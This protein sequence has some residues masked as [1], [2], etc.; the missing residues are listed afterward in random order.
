MK[1]RFLKL[2]LLVAGACLPGSSLPAAVHDFETEYGTVGFNGPSGVNPAG[3][4]SLR[5]QAAG[6][7][8]Q[9][10]DNYNLL[11]GH[12]VNLLG[13]GLDSW[14]RNSGGSQPWIGMNLTGGTVFGFINNSE[15]FMLPGTPSIAVIRWTA[16]EA[17][18]AVISYRFNDR[19]GGGDGSDWYVALNATDLAS[20]VIADLGD[21]GLNTL[22]S[23]NLA[24]GDHINWIVGAG[25][26]GDNAADVVR[27]LAR[28]DFTPKPSPTTN[29][30]QLWLKAD[31]ITALNSGA[32]VSTW[33][34]VSAN[35][36]HAI[37]PAGFEPSF[38]TNSLN[39][40]PS[41][42]FADSGD[43]AFYNY[44]DSPLPL[45]GNSQNLA[46]F[47]VFRSARV[48][49]RD[50]LVQTLN[51]PS[52]SNGRTML[53]TDNNLSGVSKVFS[54]AS[55][56]G[57]ESTNSYVSNSWRLVTLVQDNAASTLALTHEGVTSIS[58]PLVGAGPSQSWR[59]GRSKNPTVPHGLAGDIAEVLLYDRVLTGAERAVVEAYL[60]DKWFTAPR[61][62]I[63]PAPLP[64]VD[65]AWDDVSGNFGLESTKGLTPPISW[66]PITT[67][68]NIAGS[69][70]N[71]TVTAWTP[72]AT[73]DFEA[74]FAANPTNN[75]SGVWS[76]LR[77]ANDAD[78]RLRDDNYTPLVF[79]E[80]ALLG[81]SGLVAWERNS[82]GTTPWIG[83][84]LTGGN[85]FGLLDN[86]M[87][88][89]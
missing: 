58:T 17:G 12:D 20:G 54:F 55:G 33:N 56:T 71:Y 66:T 61:L 41:V 82:G 46:L 68:I 38:V 16:P 42:R 65:V 19:Q 11:T 23:V 21:T 45:S 75:P 10:D 26:G 6:A 4:W 39:G 77:Q 8:T 29:G 30:L 87:S 81:Q 80:P 85:V 24:A 27:T 73:Y 64:A 25:S 72:G 79:Y 15:S 31:A 83:I 70:R 5:Y 67:G 78:E 37:A 2:S 7:E 22:S 18:T 34:D 86:G 36:Q 53:Y 50:T 28:V 14:L 62:A 43:T 57:N 88:F 63:A 74:D 47:I 35:A 48:G 51:G 49:Q 89:L 13:A 32:V 69:R 1:L 60:L 84:N 9:R 59:F 40:L 52:D 76:F 44:L 3:W